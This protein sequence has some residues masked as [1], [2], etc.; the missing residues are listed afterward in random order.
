MA[1][2]LTIAIPT[3]NRPSLIKN[4]LYDLDKQINNLNLLNDIEI[5]VSDNSENNQTELIIN[6]LNRN[7]NIKINYYKNNSDQ[8]LISQA[9]SF[10]SN[11]NNLFKNS[12]SKYVWVV[13]D[14][15]FI[16]EDALNI[17]NKIILKNR[18]IFTNIYVDSLKPYTDLSDDI[19]THDKS[20][21]C[22]LTKFRSGHIAANIFNREIWLSSI[23]QDD[24]GSG[25]IHNIYLIKN[26]GKNKTYIY[27]DSLKDEY[28]NF[29]KYKYDKKYKKVFNNNYYFIAFLNNLELLHSMNNYDFDNEAIL[30]GFN[31]QYKNFLSTILSF[32]HK[33][34]QI[35][36]KILKKFL[37]STRNLGF[38]RYFYVFI[39]IFFPSWILR[40]LKN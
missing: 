13:G 9:H 6:D 22:K 5:V 31:L 20:Y 10:D 26:L 33:G 21:F 7:F 11:V 40:L 15:D 29:E 4:L 32:K 38:K 1:K 27:R 19:I 34:V 8:R 28:I 3:I 35:N 2:N 14:D 16:K 17:I 18:S 24:Y 30:Y 12:T 25:W 23:S 36:K 39:L 37:K